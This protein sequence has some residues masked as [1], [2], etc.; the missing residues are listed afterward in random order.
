MKKLIVATLTGVLASA[1]AQGVP[2]VAA[3]QLERKPLFCVHNAHATPF[4]TR[5]VGGR[6]VSWST[7]CLP[8]S[9]AS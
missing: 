6:S 5:E 4:Q 9:G 8:R 2:E 1:Y 3:T 7:K